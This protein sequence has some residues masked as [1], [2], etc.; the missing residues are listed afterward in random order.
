MRAIAKLE[1]RAPRRG[2]W[3]TPPVIREAAGS[4]D[5]HG[6]ASQPTGCAGRCRHAWL[7]QT[8]NPRAQKKAPRREGRRGAEQR[9]WAGGQI[10]RAEKL[11]PG[12]PALVPLQNNF[13]AKNF[14]AHESLRRGMAF[15]CQMGNSPDLAGRF[16][17]APNS[18]RARPD[19][20][21]RD[22]CLLLCRAAGWPPSR[23]AALTK[24]SKNT[25]CLRLD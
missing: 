20:A 14:A 6:A 15:I 21:I 10:K 12:C 8:M 17:P 7:E 13:F 9:A 18:P 4:V 25:I 23:L 22:F 2:L 1:S 3:P 16:R 5:L 11:K 19:P 24:A